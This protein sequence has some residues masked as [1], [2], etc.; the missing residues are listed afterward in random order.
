MFRNYL[1]SKSGMAILFVDFLNLRAL[2]SGLNIL[3][4][5]FSF[6]YAFVPSKHWMP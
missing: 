6:L 5:P 1:P 4:S 3:I 2:H